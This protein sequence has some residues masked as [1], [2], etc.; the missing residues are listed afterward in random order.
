MLER[1]YSRRERF[2]RREGFSMKRKS[3]NQNPLQYFYVVMPAD[4]ATYR[5]GIRTLCHQRPAHE[6]IAGGSSD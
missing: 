5:L 1:R 6:R 2:T 3:L 4:K